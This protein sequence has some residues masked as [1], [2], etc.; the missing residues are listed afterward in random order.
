MVSLN[1]SLKR[2]FH[3]S[4]G[5]LFLKADLASFQCD[6]SSFAAAS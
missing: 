3:T 2:L 4:L 5:S 6:L 1:G